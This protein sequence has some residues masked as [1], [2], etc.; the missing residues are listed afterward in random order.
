MLLSSDTRSAAADFSELGI[1]ASLT[2]P[3]RQ[4]DL[5][6]AVLRALHVRLG[7]A[8]GIPLAPRPR[9][10]AGRRLRVLLAEDNAVNQ[11][12][13]TRLLEG[14][15]HQVV[16]A[17]NGREALAALNG[18]P[19]DV[20][21]MDVQMPELD[22][23]EA[24][25]ALREREKAAGRRTP[26]LALTAHALKGD[27]E[28]CLEAGMDGYLAK[29]IRSE[30]LFQALQDLAPPAPE[31]G[32]R[33]EVF[34]RAAALNGVGQSEALLREIA[35]VFLQHSPR[36]L[37]EVRAALDQ[38]D[39]AR[40]KRAVH[41]LRGSAAHFAAAEAVAAARGLEAM[42][43]ANDLGGAAEAYQALEREVRRLEQALTGVASPPASG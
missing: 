2:K 21:L 19:F 27:R 20:V 34:D 28:R 3:I 11:T 18:G 36:L 5:L 17:A 24:T 23:F 25:A 31:E 6:Q 35:A 15:G 42:A 26:V 41:S 22:G 4:S 1:A 32:G 40:L 16:L 38:G 37:G 9:P 10:A 14:Q 43:E 39:V 33:A 7:E 8:E 12:L 30:D 13:V 29:P